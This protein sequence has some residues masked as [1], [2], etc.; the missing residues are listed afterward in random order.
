MRVLVNY[1]LITS[2]KNVNEP[3][4][5]LKVVKNSKKNWAKFYLPPLLVVDLLTLEPKMV[6]PAL[7]IEFGILTGLDLARC[8][9]EKKDIYKEKSE[10]DLKEL[11]ETFQCI[12]FDTD[13]N[14][15]L[16]SQQYDKKYNVRL[17]ENKLPTMIEQKYILV[18][19]Y[20]NRGVI[21]DTSFVQEH[22]V[23]SN[24]YVL[25]FGIPEKRLRPVYLNN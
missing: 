7:G 23:G 25:T 18:P 2:I 17:N 15:L 4:G 20:A 5:P 22:V 8:R 9:V 19:Y 13:Y 16:R 1:D 11:A 14:Q 21:M 24:S 10:K 3:L 12:G 6:P